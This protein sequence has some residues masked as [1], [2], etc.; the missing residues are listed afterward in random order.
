[1]SSVLGNNIF[2]ALQKKK[3]K[4][5]PKSSES[6]AEREPKVDKHAEIEKALFSAPAASVSNWADELDDEWGSAPAPALSEHGWNEV[7][8]VLLLQREREREKRERERN[9]G[10]KKMKTQGM[11]CSG[12]KS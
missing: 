9:G 1:M 8:V 11:S 6:S 2:T 7:S 12:T 3:S 10:R 5:K 4:S